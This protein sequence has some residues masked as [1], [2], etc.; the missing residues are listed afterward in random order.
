MQYVIGLWARLSAAPPR[1]VRWIVWSVTA[2]PFVIAAA[3][4]R[5]RRW[6]PVLDMAMTELR[7]RDVG[8]RHTPLI[9][10]PG[11]IGVFP[12]Q[13]SH[14]GPLSFSLLA[15]TYRLLGASAWSMLVGMIVLALIAIGLAL[16]I[17]ERRGGAPL[18]VA[19]AG[20]VALIVRGFGLDVVT[21]PWNP[22]LPL[23]FW[24]V[25][26]L[27][28]WS[29]V[30]G[31]HAMVVVVAGAG[32]LCAQT[33]LPYLGLSL[34]LSGVCALALAHTWW[35]HPSR[36]G[37]V[38]RW[39]VISALVAGVLWVPPVVDQVRHTPGNLSALRDY[40]GNPPDDP[41]G[42]IEG[43]R[44][45]LRHLD[46]FRLVGGAFGDDGFV[47]RAGLRLDGSV[48]PGLVVLAV[49]T[50]CVVLAWRR[51]HRPLLALDVTLGAALV[52]GAFSMGRIFGKVWY[53]LTLW[54][55]TTTWLIAAAIVWTVVVEVRHR[56]PDRRRAAR[57]AGAAVVAIVGVGSSAALTVEA[58]GVRAPEQHVSDTLRE[59][60]APTVAALEQNAGL[61]TGRSGTYLVTWDD[62]ANFGSQGY[63]LVNELERRGFDVGVPNTWRVPVT[64]HRVVPPGQA[65]AELRLATGVYVDR[66]ATLP[67]AVEVARYEPR[68]PDEM[69]EYERLHDEVLAALVERGLDELVPSLDDNLFS[70]LLAGDL[71]REVHRT[72][73][74]MLVLGTTTVVFLLPPDSPR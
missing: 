66:V 64:H 56:W 74:R 18:V 27:A 58:F 13:G 72:V 55:W 30:D 69:V 49:W 4:L 62:A 35:R 46:V 52:L 6:N 7:V 12:D 34:G 21:Q 57:M 11:R 44:L 39:A 45:A 59:V 33:H 5:D 63:G 73:D 42:M 38:V 68:D 40:F 14:P 24:L 70:L 41:V 20:L 67:G 26:L 2:I 61:A 43:V 47:T 15:P 37:E 17:A 65:T 54:A 22:Y 71:P 28:T 48:V 9:G 29:V 16:W 51:R 25:V 36:R 31:D 60:V 1:R 8:G 23:L 32:S 50:A 3:V 19:M 10:L 53:Y